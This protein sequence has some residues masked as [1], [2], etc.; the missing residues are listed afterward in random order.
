M[1]KKHSE[2]SSTEATVD[3]QSAAPSAEEKKAKPTPKRS[4]QVRARKQ[5]LVPEK[6][7][8]A[9]KQ[10]RADIKRKRQEARIGV[11]QGD[12][13]YLTGRDAGPQ[14]KYVRDFIDARWCIGE[15]FI[16]VAMGALIVG[17]ALSYEYRQIL[18]IAVYAVVLLVVLDCFIL[19]YQ[20]KSR[21]A[22]KFGGKEKLE[23]G[24]TFYA[25]TRAVQ[26]RPLRIPK[27][28]RKHGDYPK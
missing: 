19:N 9:T 28:Q 7:K 14:R 13:R 23:R 10:A 21:M 16:P 18:N 17:M 8:E 26:L 20:M 5:P 15:I 1:A 6:S 24:L 4:E 11:M 3:Q 12:E 27:V 25:V 2:S 22:V